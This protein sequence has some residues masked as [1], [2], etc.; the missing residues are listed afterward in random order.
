MYGNDI[1]IC[2]MPSNNYACSVNV[3]KFK[4]CVMFI[5]YTFFSSVQLRIYMILN[6]LRQWVA[7]K[8]HE[9]HI[10]F[11]N[12]LITYLITWSGKCQKFKKS[13][14]TVNE[15]LLLG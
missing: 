6:K 8:Y 4:N 2:L 5:L 13:H 14:R 3:G 7:D 11:W 12:R 15:Q 9:L 10:A 1:V